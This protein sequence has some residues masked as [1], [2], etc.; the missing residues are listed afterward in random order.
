[1]SSKSE[2]QKFSDMIERNA[3]DKNITHID[4]IV[5]Y[6]DRTGLELT[7]VNSL[8]T[9][10]LKSKIEQEAIHARALKIK[11]SSTVL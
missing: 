4:A 5:D 11:R 10:S 1:M 3:L 8:V 2:R 7:M 6:C 9:V